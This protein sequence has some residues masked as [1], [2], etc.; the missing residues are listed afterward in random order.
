MADDQGLSEGEAAA[1]L[2]AEGPNELSGASRLPILASAAGIL[3]EPMTALL[4]G[5]GAIYFFIGDRQEAL[6]LL[7]F[8]LLIAA[9]T[10]FQET[11]TER[12]LVALRTMASPRALVIRGGRRRR[13]AGREVVRG[14]LLVLA[15]GDRVPADAFVLSTAGCAA[16]ESLLTG[17]S[18]PV[19]K[20]AWGGAE[21]FG[22]PGGED[23]PFVYA[24]TLVV[25]GGARA[26]ACA[27]GARTEM[28]RIGALLSA[29]EGGAPPAT[30]LQQETR[31]L[32][33]RIA[34][35]AGA[36]SL[37]AFVLHGLATRS[38]VKGLL[39]GLTLAMAI[40]P[41]ELPVV[42]T[43]FLA[44]GAFRLSRHGVLARRVPAVE[45]LGSATVLCVDKTGTLTRNE[46]AVSRFHAA[47]LDYRTERLGT[48]TLPE[49]FHP[50][51]EYSILASRPDPFDPMERAFH[52]LGNV[53][54]QGSEHLHPD[55]AL[56][57]EYPM[58]PVLAVGQLW[59][60]PAGR[61]VAAVKGAPEAVASL[62]RVPPVE[63]EELSAAAG[64][65]AG[66]GLRV[67]A[68]AGGEVETAPPTI[69]A[70]PLRM[71]GLVGLV[72]P[73]RDGVPEAVGECRAAGI[74]VAVVSGD[75]PATVQSVGRA[76]GITRGT[77]MTGPELA[78]IPDAELPRRVRGV[79]LFAR[80]LP[81]EKLRLVRALQAD[82]EIVAMTGDGVNDAPALRAADIGVAMGERGTDVAREAGQL[83]LLHDDFTS[84]AAAV[85]IGRRVVDNLRKALA[86]LLAIHLPILGL[87]LVPIALS[88]PLVLL[89]AHIA[90]LHLIID[91][92]SSV[93]FEAEPEEAGVMRR[94][95]RAPRSSLFDAGVIASSA[96]QGAL[97]LGALLSLLGW[98]RHAGRS[99]DAVRALGFAALVVA[100]LSLAVLNATAPGGRPGE[101]PPRR[102][103]N[104]ALWWVVAGTVLLLALVLAI[105][106]VQAPFRL[107]PPRGGDLLL[108]LVAG[109]I[110]PALYA[111]GRRFSGG[112]R[113]DPRRG[114]NGP[115]ASAG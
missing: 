55:W 92:A 94:P 91:P 25:Q 105:P 112:R 114:S 64:A 18:A 1:R 73:V 79:D 16:D 49:P 40:L 5:C 27:V 100:N 68:V 89:P 11:K 13:I 46:M 20:R 38:W 98:A 60:T 21:P 28:G 101:A 72:D 69:E 6:M 63:R 43:V 2:R 17:E 41:N 115:V 77:V 45:T 19:R 106:A 23:R 71:L 67:L 103:R 86:Y 75:F 26:R 35:A 42:V 37:L 76:I 58:G 61:L 87:T 22:R 82:G 39:A 104:L 32:V 93:A 95:P 30:R 53:Q 44:L 102:Q 24:G 9:I 85:R 107:A 15:E 54:L 52:A 110:G 62:T 81:E 70:L 29:G 66:D 8:V 99:E 48:E 47:G 88:W 109:L 80:V 4:L 10:L 97:V 83:V 51:L 57:R 108:A 59:R 56:V 12:A 90:F 78:A 7:G 96:A 14:D 113:N 74:R 84:L 34:V 3:R 111:A 33:F 50:L 36:L 65:M 31:R